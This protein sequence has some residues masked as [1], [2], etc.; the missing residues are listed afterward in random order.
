MTEEMSEDS[1]TCGLCGVDPV[2]YE[3]IEIGLTIINV[4]TD[5]YQVVAR[6]EREALDKRRQV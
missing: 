3:S 6:L 2:E 5:C 1:G 4:C